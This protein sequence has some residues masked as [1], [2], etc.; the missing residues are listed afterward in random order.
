MRDGHAAYDDRVFRWDNPPE[1]G[2]PGEAHNCRCFAEPVLP[3]V[4]NNVVLADFAPTAGGVPALDPTDAIRGLRALTGVGAAL[5][6]SNALQDWTEAMRDRRV[7]EAGAQLG[8]DVTTVEGRLAATAYALVQEGISSGGYSVLPKTPGFARIGAEAAA[9]FELM[10]PG[11]I[12]ETGIDGDRAKQRAL[13][14]FIEAAGEAFA[15]GDLRLQEGELA[16]G[17][18]EVFPEL[19]EEERR[20]GELPGFTPERIDQWLETYPIEE[21]GLPNH[22]GTPISD[23]PTDNII[24]TPIPEETGPN[25][26]AMENPHSIDNISIPEDR[27]RHILDGEGRSGGHRFG[28]GTPGKTEFPESWSDDDVLGAIR[29]V[30]GNGVVDRPA[31]REG[32]L[33]I[34]GEVDGV[35]IEVVVQPNGEVRTAYPLSGKGVVRNPR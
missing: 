15:Q 17:W 21:L 29:E 4:P 11:T 18:V 3:G 33:V 19:T 35:I 25:I 8:V 26:V 23:D 10:N 32:D 28:T 13:Q 12:L 34:A 27:E 31:H 22:T 30:A 16:Q 7:A 6:A 9:L 5:L 14:D 20:L 24:S 1:G 2:H